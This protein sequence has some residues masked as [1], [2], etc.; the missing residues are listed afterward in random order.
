[1]GIDLVP[2]KTCSYDCIYCQLGRTTNHTVERKEYVP[3]DVV[4]EELDCRLAAGAEPDYVTLSGSGEPALYSRLA[5][6]IAGIKERIDRPVAVLTNGSLLWDRDV[7]E[8]L[9]EADLVIPSLDAGDEATFRC[10][11]RPHPAVTFERMVGGIEEFCRRFRKRVWLEVIFVK[12][13]NTTGSQQEKIARLIDRI[14]PDRVQ[15]NTVTRPPCEE[16]AVAMPPEELRQ[17]ARALGARAEVIAEFH[18]ADRS[19]YCEARREDILNL[20]MRRPCTLEEVSTGLGLH[21]NEVVKYLD[22]LL[23]EHVL[24]YDGSGARAFYRFAERTGQDN[25]PHG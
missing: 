25:A 18:V 23:T 17:A 20:L 11:N 6:L 7:Q 22:E 3:L 12:D 2:F 16:F 21:P 24:V 13:L 9:L 4:L 19:E 15:L 1:M 8:S 14:M 5:A 10:V